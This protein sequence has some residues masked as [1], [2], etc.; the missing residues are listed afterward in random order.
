MNDFW[1]RFGGAI[2]FT[3]YYLNTILTPDNPL[4]KHAY[5][6]DKGYAYIGQTFGSE[7]MIEVAEYSINSDRSIWPF[8]DEVIDNGL[9]FQL[10]H[11][12]ETFLYPQHF[13]TMFT[14]AS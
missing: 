13:H 6:E 12:L 10:S 8:T 5:F 7:I 14:F 4:Y 1:A 2:P 9:L 11:Q 3:I